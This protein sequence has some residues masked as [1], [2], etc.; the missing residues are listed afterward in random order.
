VTFAAA[1]MSGGP[2]LRRRSARGWAGLLVVV[3]LASAGGVVSISGDGQVSDFSCGNIGG[4]VATVRTNE[5]SYAPGQT[6][7]ISVTQANEGPTC[8]IL[9][10][11]CGPA[12]PDAAAYN[13][14][15]EPVWV[16]GAGKTL[17]TNTCFTGPVTVTWRARSSY[18]QKYDWSQ[19][20]CTVKVTRAGQASPD[21]PGTQVPA[22]RY[23]IVGGNG[24]SASVTITISRNTP[25]RMARQSSP[26]VPAHS[27]RS[28]ARGDGSSRPADQ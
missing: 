12:A 25:V 21:C 6:V 9:V 24:P 19:D 1:S 18:S 27:V 10:P 2:K 4:L 22:G 16:Y 7:I 11:P 28:R 13:S 23:R 20:K 15:G 3:A 8:S 17:N 26:E 14:A 5:P